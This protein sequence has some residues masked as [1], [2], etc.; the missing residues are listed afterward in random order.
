M[1][2]TTV[3]NV[4]ANRKNNN[5]LALYSHLMSH[6]YFNNY[7]NKTFYKEVLKELYLKIIPCLNLNYC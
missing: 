4:S 1:E 7:T 5:K 3:Q 2:M 6:V